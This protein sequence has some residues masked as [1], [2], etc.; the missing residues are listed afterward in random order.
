MAPTVIALSVV[1]LQEGDAW[2]AQALEFD[3]AAQGKTLK[4]ASD[5]FERT[6]VGQLIV[7]MSN[8][9]APFDGIDQAPKEYWDRFDSAKRI[10]DMGRPLRLPVS[11][12]ARLRLDD[13][14]VEFAGVE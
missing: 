6:V 4:A 11:S 10:E 9:Q 3:I 5:A 14:R 13:M 7:D 12:S 2:V 1:L 8:G